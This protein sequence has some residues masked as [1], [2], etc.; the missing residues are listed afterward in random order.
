MRKRLTSVKR[1][2]HF[3][4]I[5]QHALIQLTNMIIHANAV[6]DLLEEIVKLKLMNAK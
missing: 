3:A 5:I 1:E 6:L 2:T 4:L